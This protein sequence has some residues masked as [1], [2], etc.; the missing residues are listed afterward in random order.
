MGAT[1]GTKIIPFGRAGARF[2][3]F[4]FICSGFLRKARSEARSLSFMDQT[5]PHDDVHT[6]IDQAN[7]C[8]STAS[9]SLLSVIVCHG[10]QTVLKDRPK[11][12]K[13][14]GSGSVK[15]FSVLF[16]NLLINEN[17]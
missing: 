7:T 2:F 17:N 10:L 9:L 11:P 3:G 12:K 6:Q 1:K 5:A 4:V 15:I 13:R 16:Q 8:V 14:L